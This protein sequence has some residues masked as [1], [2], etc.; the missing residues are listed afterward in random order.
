M[1][2]FLPGHRGGVNVLWKLNRMLTW[3]GLASQFKIQEAELPARARS[4]LRALS[5]AT[6]YSPLHKFLA[7]APVSSEKSPPDPS[8]VYLCKER[9]TFGPWKLFVHLLPSSG[10]GSG[11]VQT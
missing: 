11:P 4:R 3:E 9:P 6:S 5:S 10:P 8:S 1:T 2:L 7:Q